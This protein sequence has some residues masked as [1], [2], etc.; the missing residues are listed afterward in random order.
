MLNFERLRA[1]DIY[2]SPFRFIAA[3]HVLATQDAAD[4]RRDFPDIRKSGF[5]ALSALQ[6]QG[7]FAELVHDLQSQELADCLSRLLD[8]DLA[9]KPRMITVRRYSKIGDGRI[10]NDS[11]SKICTML[12]YLNERWDAREGG[13][14]RALNGPDDMNDYTF[15]TPPLAGNV[16]AFRRSEAS[17]HGHPAFEGERLVV[18]TTFLTSQ[19]ELDRKERRG[20]LQHLLKRVNPFA[21]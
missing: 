16:F 14:V 7:A 20:G 13:A 6:S 18:Q 19:E 9:E 10:H 12:I 3:E 17:W 2:E 1:A 5:L 4:I 8:I 11:I 21:R 15:E